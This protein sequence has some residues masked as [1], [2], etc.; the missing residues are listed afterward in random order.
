MPNGE[1]NDDDFDGQY[2]PRLGIWIALAFGLVFWGFV[3]LAISRC[4]G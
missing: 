4:T 2:K 1:Q 3:G